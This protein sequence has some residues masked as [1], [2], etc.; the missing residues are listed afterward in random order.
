MSKTIQTYEVIAVGHGKITRTPEIKFTIEIQAEEGD[1]FEL[2][3]VSKREA[4]H[5][6]GCEVVT[7]RSLKRLEGVVRH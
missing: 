2:D 6:T 4:K 1:Y 5:R 3:R 7:I